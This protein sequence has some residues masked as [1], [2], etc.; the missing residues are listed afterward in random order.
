MTEADIL[1]ITYYDSCSIIRKV[2]VVKNPE[3][4]MSRQQSVIVGTDIPCALSTPTGG[5]I[6]H[7]EGHGSYHSGYTLFCRPDVDIEAGDKLHV[8]TKSGRKYTLWA[9]RPD[10]FTGSHTA[11]PLS[12]EENT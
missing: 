2:G 5:S 10:T 7:S 12:E 4:G 8:I 6:N 9:G 3:T 11:T 1:A